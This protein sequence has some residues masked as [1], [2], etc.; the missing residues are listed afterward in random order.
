MPNPVLD[1][2]SN[3]EENLNRWANAL[4]GGGD[5]LAVFKVVYSGK[6]SR[7]TG[8]E[9]TEALGGRIP[10]KRVVMA[11]KK[12][13]GD[14]LLRQDPEA[15]PVVYEKLGDVHHYKRRILSLAANG[16][17][18]SALPTKRSAQ[19]TVRSAPSKERD[20]GGRA[21]NVTIDDVDQFARVRRLKGVQRLLK[22][23]SEKRFKRGL[24]KLFKETGKF[25]DWGGEKN[26]FFTNKLKMNGK[27]YDTAFALKGPGVRRKTM[28]PGQWGVNGNQIQRL[29]GEAPGAVFFLQF[30]GQ[31]DQYSIEQLKK[32]T[33]H[34]ATQEKRKLFYGYIDRDDA[35]R[36]RRAYPK[37]F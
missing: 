5:K 27:R 31:I 11:G 18:R 33:E 7:W 14:G 15:Y 4:K 30:E 2:G 36:L 10:P 35:L 22:P 26:D 19:I 9:I 23:L 16:R 28:G 1:L 37:V 3:L 6:R 20:R 13:H 25:P 24:L 21:I 17:K 12:L 34:R 8:S 32:L 29:V